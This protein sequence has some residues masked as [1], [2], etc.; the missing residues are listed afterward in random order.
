MQKFYNY[1][2]FSGKDDAINNMGG[3]EQLYH[4]Y[5]K[6]FQVNHQMTGTRLTNYIEDNN[7]E[8]AY[9]LVHSVHGIALTLGMMA[10]SQQAS[11]LENALREG[12]YKNLP[13]LVN[14]FQDALHHV[15]H[16]T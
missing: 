12:R 5:V 7:Y 9:I 11:T 14:S 13:P 1:D 6:R 15:I 4:K 16:S 2:P 3:A 10:L 8:N